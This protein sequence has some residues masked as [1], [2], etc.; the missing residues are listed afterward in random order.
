MEKKVCQAFAL[1]NPRRVFQEMARRGM[2]S[3]EAADRISWK[4]PINSELTEEELR[5]AGVTAD[6]VA[7]G[8][9]YMTRSHARV[10]P[11]VVYGTPWCSF[12]PRSG[13]AGYHFLA[14]G[15]MS[16]RHTGMLTDPKLT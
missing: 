1:V 7:A 3:Q 8:I 12:W 15:A 6:L 4:C 13:R 14:F 5:A 2:V 11:C 16:P 9:L 10:T